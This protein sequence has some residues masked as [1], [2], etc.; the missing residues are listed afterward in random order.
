MT[1]LDTNVLSEVTKLDP[2]TVVLRWLNRQTPSSLAIASISKAELLYGTESMAKGQ[3]REA[4][5]SAIDKMLREDFGDRILPFDSEAAESYAR[6]VASR[7]KAGKP[8]SEAD[9]QIAAI[10]HSQGAALATRN[11]KDFQGCDIRLLN[12]WS[13]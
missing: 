10:A 2:S 5:L 9:A 11:V 13:E 4:L 1:I 7:R 12:P 3:R 8:I 6:I